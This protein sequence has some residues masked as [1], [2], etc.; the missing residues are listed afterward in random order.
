MSKATKEQIGGE[1]YKD[2]PVQPAEFVQKNK[3][4]YLEASSIYYLIR[5]RDKGGAQDL[6]KVIHNC[7]LILEMEYG[8]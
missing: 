1:H 4:P 7:Q 5:H 8:E 2:Y 6:K 3:I